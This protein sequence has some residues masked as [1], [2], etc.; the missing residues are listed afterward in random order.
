[1]LFTAASFCG[2]LS[3]ALPQVCERLCLACLGM[4]SSPLSSP[5]PSTKLSPEFSVDFITTEGLIFGASSSLMF[6]NS[7][8][9]KVLGAFRN[10]GPMIMDFG[11]I[12]PESFFLGATL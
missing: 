9:E 12:C 6:Y 4:K 10:F 11:K 5:S 3:L 2:L 1:M 7:T 8:L